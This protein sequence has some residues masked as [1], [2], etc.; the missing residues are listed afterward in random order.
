MFFLNINFND[1]ESVGMGTGFI[2][3]NSLSV[4]ATKMG[5]ERETMMNK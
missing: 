2:I 3:I 1:I 4:I 5:T